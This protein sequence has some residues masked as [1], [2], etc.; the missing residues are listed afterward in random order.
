LSKKIISEE[1][2]NRKFYFKCSPTAKTDE[3]KIVL[4]SFFENDITFVEGCAGT[5]KSYLATTWALHEFG[6]GNYERII[7]TRPAVEAF[8]EKL[9]FLPGDADEKLAPYMF[10]LVSF[11][12]DIMTETMLNTLVREKKILTIPLAF[13]RGINFHKAIVVGDEFQN[14]NAKQMRMFL[15]RLELGSKIIV[16]GDLKQSDVSEENGL[17]DALERFIDIEGIGICRLTEE[18]ITRH[19]IIRQI[20]NGYNKKI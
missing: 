19:P 20:E 18:S 15:T 5:G 6:K 3:Q 7:F 16:T 11:M 2:E 9:G 14:T 8:G 1:K 12:L 4:K 10:P 13:Q 17:K